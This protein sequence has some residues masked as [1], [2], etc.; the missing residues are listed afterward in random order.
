MKLTQ[1]AFPTEHGGWGFLSEAIILGL[2]L[3]P[4]SA[5]I[6]MALSAFFFFLLYQPVK[7]FLAKVSSGIQ[8]QTSRLT[9]ILLGPD[10]PA[11]DKQGEAKLPEKNGA[12]K[13]RTLALT[14]FIAGYSLLAG[15]F[16]YLALP[17]VSSTFWVIPGL[18]LPLLAIQWTSSWRRDVR[19]IRSELSGAVAVAAMAP[20]IMVV[21]GWTLQS[22]LLVWLLLS[23]RASS[24]IHFIR[25]ALAAS[26]GKPYSLSSVRRVYLEGLVILGLL[27]LLRHIPILAFF[28]FGYMALR[29]IKRLRKC[30]N[31]K[32][33]DLGLSELRAGLL[34]VLLIA[35]GYW[36]FV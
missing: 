15:L 29:A 7:I 27:M 23:I 17:G 9:M 18:T 36:L 5:G 33:K 21:G 22:A 31:L 32:A 3:A 1:L 24:S 8:P 34:N 35:I 28:S 25:Q 26:R 10:F 30:E 12:D 13:F 11:Q 14:L 2:L 19:S 6:W 4:S 16:L 20:M